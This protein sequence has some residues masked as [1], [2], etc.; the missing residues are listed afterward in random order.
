MQTERLNIRKFRV[1]DLDALF[2]L[3]SDEDVMKELEPPYTR[4]KTEAFLHQFGI[5][6][7]PLIYAVEDR[8]KNF[9]GYVIYHL[10]E[11][12]SY[13]IGWVLRKNQWG[14][15]YAGELTQCLIADA[16]S[17]QKNLIIECAPSQTVTKQIAQRFHFSFAG[18]IDGLEVYTLRF[19]GDES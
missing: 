2:E 15:G 17:K 13:E 7:C 11:A 19:H 14:K 16:K 10:Y 8:Q 3:L 5:A 1:D 18:C 6:E 4:D 12:D 9:V